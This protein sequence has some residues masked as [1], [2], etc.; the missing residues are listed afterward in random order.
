MLY[1]L[2]QVRRSFA[3]CAQY[4]KMQR[5]MSLHNDCILLDVETCFN[6]H[7]INDCT[8]AVAVQRPPKHD[9]NMLDGSNCLPGLEPRTT[10]GKGFHKGGGRCY[11]ATIRCHHSSSA[12][13]SV[14][15]MSCCFYAQSFP[16][17]NMTSADQLQW[18]ADILHGD[19]QVDVDP[20]NSDKSDRTSGATAT[21]AEHDDDDGDEDFDVRDSDSGSER[22]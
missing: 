9:Q 2:Q 19:P 8:Y 12:F 13:S 17:I 16:Q 1:N 10:S 6:N 4:C 22:K 11:Q 18:L 7:H 5:K 14:A 21:E 20:P 15:Y 3:L